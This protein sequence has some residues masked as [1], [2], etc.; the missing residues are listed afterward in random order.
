MLAM[1]QRPRQSWMQLFRANWLHRLARQALDYP[2][3]SYFLQ[4]WVI[5]PF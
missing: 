5:I 4:L 3:P 2:D 1:R